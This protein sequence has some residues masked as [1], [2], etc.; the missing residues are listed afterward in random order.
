MTGNDVEMNLIQPW[1]HHQC[2]LSTGHPKTARLQANAGKINHIELKSF[3]YMV[4][5]CV[6]LKTR[7]VIYYGYYGPKHSTGRL[8]VGPGTKPCSFTFESK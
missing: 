3:E 1:K 8:T 7:M 4:W 6:I 5:V 2:L